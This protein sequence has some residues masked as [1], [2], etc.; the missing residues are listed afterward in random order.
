MPQ[1][2]P[3]ALAVAEKA[4]REF[5]NQ[6]LSG[7]Q[8]ILSLET[9]SDGQIHVILKVVAGAGDA[10]G[11]HEVA[12]PRGGVDEEASYLAAKAAQRLRRR[13]PSYG[14]RLSKS[15]CRQRL[16]ISPVILLLITTLSFPACL[17]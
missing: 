9:A 1:T 5:R 11:Q 3:L 8:P 2:I 6:W 7:L 13:S 17:L 15:L 12:L 14:Q 4:F 16:R 10:T